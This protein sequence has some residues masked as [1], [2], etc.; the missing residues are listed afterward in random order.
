MSKNVPASDAAVAPCATRMA[1]LTR[2]SEYW[3]M[4]SG[5]ILTT[6]EVGGYLILRSMLAHGG[7]V[8]A[9]PKRLK[10][11]LGL[12]SVRQVHNILKSMGSQFL[13]VLNDGGKGPWPGSDD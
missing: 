12:S 10:G 4:Y 1:L 11:A 5:T 9:D 8:S 2:D 13:L 6:E 7:R 3:H